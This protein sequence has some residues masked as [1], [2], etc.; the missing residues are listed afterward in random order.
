[1]TSPRPLDGKV[2]VITGASSPEGIGAASARRL[3]ASGARLLLIAEGPA[4]SLAA[5]AQECAGLHGGADGA[6]PLVANLADA[7]AAT[8]MIAEAERR[9]GRVD[10]LVNNAGVRSFKLFGE[11]DA[12][13]FDL[14]VAVNIRAPFL[15]SQ[16]VLPL[17]RRQGGGRIIH[18]ASQLGSVAAETRALYGM[19]KAALIHLAKTMALELAR[20]NIQVNTV[21]PGPTATRP[22][23]RAPAEQSRGLEGAAER[24][25]GGPLRTA[26]GDRR[27]GALAA[28]HRRHVPDRPRSRDRRRLRDPLTSQKGERPRLPRVD[29]ASAAEPTQ[30]DLSHWGQTTAEAAEAGG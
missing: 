16:A 28:H 23:P 25:P 17:M 24:R 14:S 9:F 26:R 4:D 27:G 11:Y 13:E 30:D 15:A 6:L 7:S 1:M 18:V 20:E 19:T 8:A 29:G 12:A 2:A 3:A 22:D 5:V 10:F 21:S